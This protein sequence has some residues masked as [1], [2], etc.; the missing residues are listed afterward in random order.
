MNKIVK[1]IPKSE[2]KNA[3]KLSALELNKIYLSDKRTILTPEILEK[4]GSSKQNGN[5]KDK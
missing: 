4:L 1:S 2:I 5:N 3:V